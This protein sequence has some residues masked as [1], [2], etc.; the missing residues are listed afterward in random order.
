MAKQPVEISIGASPRQAAE[1]LRLLAEDDEFR[2]RLKRSPQRVLAEYD[3]SVPRG[4]IPRPVTLPPP[5][6]IREVVAGMTR[7]GQLRKGGGVEGW[8]PFFLLLGLRRPSPT[9]AKRR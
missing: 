3:I 4:A 5:E 7:S 1:F 6:V 2:R 8:W 9:A